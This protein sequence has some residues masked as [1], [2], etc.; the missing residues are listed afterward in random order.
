MGHGKY[1]EIGSYSQCKVDVANEIRP[2]YNKKTKLIR[3]HSQNPGLEL[4]ASLKMSARTE[5]VVQA[6]V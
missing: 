4:T 5:S 1:P 3:S 2:I 6:L